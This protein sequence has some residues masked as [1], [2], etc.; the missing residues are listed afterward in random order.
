M[1]NSLADL[2]QAI[3]TRTTTAEAAAQAQLARI[4]ATE[5]SVGAWQ[6]LD[7]A[8]V[9]REA[10][11][12]DAALPAGPIAGVGIGVKDIIATKDFPTTV[13]SPIYADYRPDNDAACVAHLRAAGAYVFGKTVTTP[14]AFMDPGRTRNPHHREHTPGGS[15]SGS[16][17]AV[18]AGHVTGAIG[19]QTNGSVIRP[20]AY[21]GVVGYKPTIGAIPVHGMHPFSPTFDTVGTFARSVSDAA[22]LASALVDG[23]RLPAAIALPEHRPRFAW[24]AQFPWSVPDAATLAVLAAAVD[25]LGADVEI[26]PIS[27]PAAW[28]DIKA[29]QRMIMLQEGFEVLGELQRRERA[30]LTPALNAAIDEGRGIAVED[31]RNACVQRER[32]IAFFTGWLDEFDAVLAPSAPSTA[33]RGLDTTGDPSCCTLWSFLGFPAVTV[34]AGTA[35]GLPVG[36]QLAAPQG[37]DAPLLTAALWVESQLPP[38]P[39]PA[40]LLPREDRAA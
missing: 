15:S 40:L 30:R 24:L 14:F 13:G 4:D 1:T 26:V 20:A 7:R 33:P 6:A 35:D 27:V 22:L 23:S 11:A 17:A 29:L 39:L 2:A 10:R 19:T 38:A 18:A 5:A 16:A 34:P 12:A 37:R 21:C 8:Y 3:R 28:Q 9:E 25:E 31:Y 32:A 36:L